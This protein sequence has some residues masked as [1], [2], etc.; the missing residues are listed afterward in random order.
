MIIACSWGAG[1]ITI[2]VQ[3]YQANSLVSII[4]SQP[5]EQKGMQSFRRKQYD[6]DYELTGKNKTKCLIKV[7]HKIHIISHPFSQNSQNSVTDGELNMY[8]GS[9]LI[10]YISLYYINKAINITD[11]LTS[12]NIFIANLIFV[13]TSKVRD[14]AKVRMHHTI[15]RITIP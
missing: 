15:L 11:S 13:H 14:V 4:S 5:P 10:K 8:S 2:S 7:I 6:Y 1:H 3:W 12:N 9:N